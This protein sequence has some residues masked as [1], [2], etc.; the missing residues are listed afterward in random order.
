VTQRGTVFGVAEAVLD[1]GPLP[2]PRLELH[3]LGWGVDGHVGGDEAV[4]VDGVVCERELVGVDG[5]SPP[6][7]GSAEITL[8]SSRTRRTT[9]QV[10]RGQLPGT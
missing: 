10:A 7:S 4:G 5:A 9:K 6:R 3:G 2:V 1:I 8:A